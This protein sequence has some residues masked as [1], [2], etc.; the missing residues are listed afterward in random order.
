MKFEEIPAW[1]LKGP[2]P[3]I[4]TFFE[5]IALAALEGKWIRLDADT[6]REILGF[7]VFGKQELKVESGGTVTVRRSACFGL[8]SEW[9]TYEAMKVGAAAKA[10]KK[11]S[12]GVTGPGYYTI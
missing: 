9:A 8:D 5:S 10:G 7:P 3:G 4:L 11:L 2:P 1:V 6:Q 12:P